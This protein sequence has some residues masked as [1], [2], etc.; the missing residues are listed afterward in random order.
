MGFYGFTRKYSIL[1]STTFFWKGYLLFAAFGITAGA[2]R[3]WSHRAYK[4]NKIAQIILMLMYST[5]YQ[6][7]IY[8]WARDHRLHHKHAETDADPHNAK[9]GFFFSHVGWLMV[10]KH[11]DV[12]EKGKTL[13][14][15]DLE[16]NPIV[17]FHHKYYYPIILLFTFIIPTF[18]P[19]YFFG[20]TLE[21]AFFVCT[22][23]RY[24]LQVNVTWCINSLAHLYG[25]KP[26][27]K[28]IGPVENA[29]MKLCSFG[30]GFHNY[31]HSFP[32]DYKASETGID[33]RNMTTYVIDGFAKL[34][35]V[36]ERKT[37]KESMIL[38]KRERSGDFK[39]PTEDR[40]S[41]V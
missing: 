18:V 17:M 12:L 13:D 1:W 20:E 10:K 8:I 33:G 19:W 4:A 25:N 9:R 32:W 35:W 14:M 29:I 28:A 26:Y 15:S 30:E 6:N 23:Y 27:D 39:I 22:I 40:K 41:V 24:I 7:S 21:N 31:H 38:K 37:V 2:H 3:L 34:G 5:T 16:A 11:P 36:T